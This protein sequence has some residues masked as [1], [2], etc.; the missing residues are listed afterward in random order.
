[1]KKGLFIVLALMMT[2]SV[3]FAGCAMSS[4]KSETADYYAEEPAYDSVDSGSQ[5]VTSEESYDD[6]AGSDGDY[7][8]KPE[9]GTGMDLENTSSVLEP[10]VERKI[11]FTGYIS[12]RTKNFDE[13]YDNLMAKVKEAGGYIENAY[14]Y[15][16]KPEE[17]Q[18]EGRYAEITLRVPSAKFD[19]FIEML[20]GVG[21]TTDSRVSGQD[22]SLQYFDIETRL[23]TLRIREERLQTLL[24]QAATLEDIIELERE[25]ANVSYEIQ[26]YEIEKRNY[27]S[28]VDFSQIT[29]NLTE[30]ADQAE[31]VAPQET[32]GERISSAFYSVLNALAVFFRGF[33]VVFIAALPILAILGVILAIVLLSVKAS[34]KKRAKKMA[35][36]LQNNQQYN[37]Q[38]N[39]QNNQQNNQPK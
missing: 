5:A 31:I 8:E 26:S 14:V 15:G 17:W 32:L 6:M 28:L 4:D 2:A 12:A 21:E 38:Y 29:V 11:I 33:L 16:T 39:Q 20:K 37:Q 24:E 36:N 3:L 25:L 9:A 10:S 18:D 1:M 23:E 27:D 7:A 34:K 30:V 35:A 19:G 13:D 22:I